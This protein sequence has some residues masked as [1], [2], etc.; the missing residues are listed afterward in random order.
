MSDEMFGFDDAAEDITSTSRRKDYKGKKDQTDRIALVWFGVD[1]K[2]N[3]KMGKEDTPKF[4]KGDV[5]YHEQVGYFLAIPGK[6]NTRFEEARTK[7]ATIVVVYPTDRS[8]AIDQNRLSS[9]DVQVMAWKM[10]PD[11]FRQLR[12]I[13]EDFPL[14]FH[15]LKVT[16]TDDTYQKM[17]F[18]PTAKE[19]LWRQVP[20]LKLRVLAEVERLSQSV[21]VGRKL[22]WEE[23]LSKLGE[24]VEAAPDNTSGYDADGLLQGLDD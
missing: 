7:I 22:T 14:T 20:E 24:E 9:G 18:S 6:T 8:G 17:T 19:A 23:I 21:D 11:K 12:G 15:D 13:H 16:C 3:P 10:S 5:H 4:I 1:E 2:G